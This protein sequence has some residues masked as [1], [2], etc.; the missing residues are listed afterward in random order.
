MRVLETA[1]REQVSA[2]FKRGKIECQFR[3]KPTAGADV[4]FTLNQGMINGLVDAIGEVEKRLPN[5]DKVR[6]TDILRWPGVMQVEEANEE[7]VRESA[8]SLLN[9][10]L[11]ELL[12]S[13][14]REGAR[15]KDF[16]LQRCDGMAELVTQARQ[17][18][19][20][21]IAQQREKL[22]ARLAD[23]DQ[24]ADQQRIEQELVIAAQKMDV[25]E[26][27]D[28]LDVHINEVRRVLAQKGP[29]GRRLDFL[30]QEFNREANTLGS[31]SV[32]A[33]TTRI[34]VDMK[35]LIEQMREQIQNIE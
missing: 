8:L 23:L 16:I 18:V 24:D 10:V 34:S 11:D 28:R 32:S 14:Q 12:A 27:L 35:V 15:L 1:V 4:A 5:A 25:D 29:V 3:F 30:M 17:R 31:K 26:E 7:Q 19:P 21:I 22:L 13:R 2:R 20:E 9:E 6:A 33:D